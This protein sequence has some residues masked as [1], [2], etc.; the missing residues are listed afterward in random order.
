MT[1]V[2]LTD[3]DV[4]AGTERHMLDLA[5]GLTGAGVDVAIGCP[6]DTPL[7]RQAID[8]GVRHREVKRGRAVDISVV[9]MLA[10]WLRSGQVKLIHAHN[11]RTAL[12]ASLARHMAGRGSIVLTQHFIQ[13][14]RLAR[15]GVK[16][17]IS[18]GMH[19]WMNRRIDHTI[20]ISNAVRD[21]AIDRADAPA[22]RI[23]VVHNGMADPASESRRPA[24]AVREELGVPLD[25]PLVVCAAR[26]QPEK[27]VGTLIDALALVAEQRPRCHGVIAGRGSEHEA[28]QQ[29][30]DQQGLGERVKLLGFRDDVRSIIAAGDVFALPAKAE[31]FGLVLL[32]AM[33][34]SQPVVATRA[35]G[36][37]D[38]VVP[39]VTGDLVEPEDASAMARAIVDL[40]DD[41]ARRRAC[42]AAGRGRFESMF[43][44]ARMAEAVAAVYRNVLDRS[45]SPVVM[46]TPV[47][48]LEQG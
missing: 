48:A 40:L 19:H 18:G 42:G 43:T 31:P 20:A 15:R 8:H 36:P 33:A 38:I 10:R 30:I 29:R 6:A 16:H 37:L 4:F 28:L 1:V 7:A 26:L 22:D 32:E 3:S 25:A 14:G 34:L 11:G 5:E 24:S 27:D 47:A 23:T 35:G 44:V 13:P 21:A 41:A 12:L 9:R 2:L 39:G 45:A 17:V 46:K